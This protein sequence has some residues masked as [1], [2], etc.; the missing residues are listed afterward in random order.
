[1]V[2]YWGIPSLPKEMNWNLCPQ[3]DRLDLHVEVLPVDFLSLT[4][5]HPEESSTEIQRRVTAA[6][7]VQSARYQNTGITCNA[8]IP[9]SALQEVCAMSTEARGLLQNVFEK[10]HLSGRAYERILKVSR[11]I[12][13]LEGSARIELPHLGEAVQYRSLDRKYWNPS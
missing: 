9:P 7:A 1:M 8:H 10:L 3:L 2:N 5:S 6:R 12:A 11:T 4:D 13:D